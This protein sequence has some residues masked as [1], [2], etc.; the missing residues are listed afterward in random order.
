MLFQFLKIFSDNQF[1]YSNPSAGRSKLIFRAPL[2]DGKAGFRDGVI[3]ENQFA[4]SE[5]NQF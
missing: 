2:P 1:V 3:T 5:V 4:G